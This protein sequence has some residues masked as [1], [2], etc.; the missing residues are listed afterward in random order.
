M[1]R[2]LV[3]G[4]LAFENIINADKPKLGIIGVKYLPTE[5]YETMMDQETGKSIGIIFDKE[6]LT[7]DLKT[8]VSNSCLGSRSIFNNL[9]STQTTFFSDKGSLIPILW[10]QLTY[11]SSGDTSADGLIS[12][13]V[14]EK[15][16]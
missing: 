4:E 16:K 1:K 13:P 7:R 3:D 10:P 6:K 15:C 8:I 14:I 9:I 2:F 11:M 12:Y 5:Y